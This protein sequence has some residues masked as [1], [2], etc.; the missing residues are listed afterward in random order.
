MVFS[1]SGPATYP[2]AAFMRFGPTGALGPIY[3]NGRGTAPEDG[4]TCYTKAGFGPSC[5]WGDYSAASSDGNGNIVMGAEM[6]PNAPRNTVAN[7]G[8]FISTLPA[9]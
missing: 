3:L 4:F 9:R 2:S 1:I 5:R 8:T 6:I 7:W